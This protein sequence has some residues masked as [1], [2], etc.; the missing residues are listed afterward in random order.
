MSNEAVPQ[1][2]EHVV[3]QAAARR[4]E[5]RPRSTNQCWLAP[6]RGARRL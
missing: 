6:L 1:T 4:S 5:A 2:V 3:S